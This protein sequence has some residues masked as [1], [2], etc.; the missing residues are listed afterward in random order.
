MLSLGYER[1]TRAVEAHSAEYLERLEFG[2]RLAS[3]GRVGAGA[4]EISPASP[5]LTAVTPIH[6][7][8][9]AFHSARVKLETCAPRL[10]HHAFLPGLMLTMI[11]VQCPL[12]SMFAL[13]KLTGGVWRHCG[14][15]PQPHAVA[16]IAA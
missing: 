3:A 16:S 6:S 15:G 2:D 7:A 9:P 4:G 14:P 5:S 1:G 12:G 11:T 8:D 13:K 10:R